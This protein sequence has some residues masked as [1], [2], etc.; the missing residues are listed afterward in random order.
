[1]NAT[2]AR[3]TWTNVETE[4]VA[5]TIANDSEVTEFW[6]QQARDLMRADPSTTIGT[7]AQRIKDQHDEPRAELSI[8]MNELLGVALDSVDWEQIARAIVSAVRAER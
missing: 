3:R 5:G 1:M 7:L 2:I 6:A 8:V 4:T